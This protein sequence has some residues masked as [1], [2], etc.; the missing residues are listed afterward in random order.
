MRRL[1]AAGFGCVG[2][3]RS[4]SHTSRRPSRGSGRHNARR[5]VASRRVRGGAE[6]S[7]ALELKSGASGFGKVFIDRAV[8][9]RDRVTQTGL[10]VDEAGGL[11][12]GRSI[13]M[14]GGKDA[15]PRRVSAPGPLPRRPGEVEDVLGNQSEHRQVKCGVGRTA[16][17]PAG[18]WRTH[19]PWGW[20]PS[21]STLALHHHLG[22]RVKHDDLRHRRRV[23]R[24]RCA[25]R[26]RNRCRGLGGR[27]AARTMPGP[28]DPPGPSEGCHSSHSTKPTRRNRPEP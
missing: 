13:G 10:R 9:R 27:R 5:E 15:A 23:Q 28:P 14:Q 1:T 21:I 2:L 22:R 24:H 11:A 8:D 19:A 25:A 26:Y 4:R 7:F 17:D 3:N 16:T 20:V 18:T 12:L 6:V